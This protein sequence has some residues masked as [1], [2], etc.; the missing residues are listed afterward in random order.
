[1]VYSHRLD[2]EGYPRTGQRQCK[3]S[4]TLRCSPSFYR[5][6]LRHFFCLR[7]SGFLS[8][9][10][11][12]RLNTTVV[13]PGVNGVT[14]ALTLSDCIVCARFRLAGIVKNSFFVRCTTIAQCYFLLLAEHFVV[15]ID[16]V[17]LFEIR[18]S[19]YKIN[20][21]PVPCLG[22]MRPNGMNVRI[23]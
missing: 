13:S 19:S 4:P 8:P 2:G 9:Q 14:L 11:P 3:G 5:R 7:H 18:H 1:M 12:H 10:C 20:L 16:D 17:A 6:P 21:S 15:S 22:N 23:D